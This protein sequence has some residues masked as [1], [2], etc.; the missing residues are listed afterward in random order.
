MTD[1]YEPSYKR[2][3]SNKYVDDDNCSFYATFIE[4]IADVVSKN[5]KEI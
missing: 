2:R 4:S 5:W 3:S 1:I